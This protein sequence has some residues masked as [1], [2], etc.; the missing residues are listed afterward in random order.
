MAITVDG[1]PTPDWSPDNP[2]SLMIADLAS[3]IVEGLAKK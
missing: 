1:M 3:M 2:G